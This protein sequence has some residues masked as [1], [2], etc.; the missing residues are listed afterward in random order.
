MEGS[1]KHLKVSFNGFCFML[2]FQFQYSTVRDI[3]IQLQDINSFSIAN[4][5]YD[6]H[7]PIS[8]ITRLIKTNETN[9]DCEISCYNQITDSKV[10]N[11]RTYDKKIAF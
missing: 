11:I 9:E 5:Y 1:N 7:F 8:L 10:W 4:L 2:Q 6:L 3:D